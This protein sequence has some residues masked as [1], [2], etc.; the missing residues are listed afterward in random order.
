[1][2][3]LKYVNGQGFVG[4]LMV[5]LDFPNKSLLKSQKVMWDQEWSTLSILL[6]AAGW[7]DPV[8]ATYAY[9]MPVT[10]FDKKGKPKL[11]DGHVS[12][13]RDWLEREIAKVAP[14]KILC[15][16]E[17]GLWALSHT[18]RSVRS[19]RGMFM[20]YHDIPLMVTYPL[21]YLAGE[22]EYFLDVA[23]DVD[24]IV[25]CN[26][27]YAHP[28]IKTHVCL[29][30]EAVQAAFKLLLRE[31]IVTVDTET[32]GLRINQDK[33]ETIGFATCKPDKS[34][35][36]A[37]IIA[38]DVIDDPD[39]MELTRSFFR[40]CAK[41]QVKVIM[42]NAKFDM[43][44]ISN[45]LGIDFE[46]ID[47]QDTMMMNYAL[48]ERP[49]NSPASPHGLKSITRIRYDVPDYHFDFDS[50][51]A[52]EHKYRDWRDMYRY[53]AQD[54]VY[55]AWLYWDLVEEL[56]QEPAKKQL[57]ETLFIPGTK[58]LAAMEQAGAAIDV[59]YLIEQGK[60]L[61][62]EMIDAVA[63]CNKAIT[64]AGF[65]FADYASDVFNPGSYVHVAIVL[66]QMF[67]L[68]KL[69]GTRDRKKRGDDDEG[70]TSKEILDNLGYYLHN[71][72]KTHPH[73]T[74][75][76]QF[77]DAVLAYRAAGKTRST[78][79]VGLVS[80]AD[81]SGRLHASF[82]L[83]G[84]STGRLS[85]TEPPLQTIPQA[86]G[87]TVRR[88]FITPEGYF[89]LKIDY[90]QLEYRMAAQLSQDQRMIQAY[91]ER[92]DIHK[93]VASA[94]LGILP[95]M[96]NKAQRYAAKFIGFGILYGRGAESIA[97]G[98]ELRGYNWTVRDAEN[99][100]NKFLGQFVGL[101]S[102]MAGT[103]EAV[104]REQKLVTPTGRVRNWQ[105]IVPQ[106]VSTCQRQALNFP[107]QSLASD[108]TLSSLIKVREYLKG[109]KSY[110]MLI[111]HDEIDYAIHIDEA[112]EVIP[113]LIRIMSNPTIVDF[114]LPIDVEA[115]FGRSWGDLQHWDENWRAV[116]ESWQNQP[117]A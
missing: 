30:K 108:V 53:L 112:D 65:R 3:T 64:E 62:Q 56:E 25:N 21:F 76:E 34:D 5:I 29:T 8:Y 106:N 40:V 91:V 55:T 54:I 46:G 117:A 13:A 86:K 27:A 51:W 90:S 26:S 79:I 63:E 17:L 66:Y 9:P 35:S 59:E 113:E 77:I 52:V 73:G 87:L 92:R 10:T 41:R 95:E 32:S 18:R 15:M 37:Y 114:S 31:P 39:V 14:T 7:T 2:G 85:A 38:Y 33:I 89:W 57:L 93:E 88:G 98:P 97:K 23:R 68:P 28:P 45:W 43:T 80:K 107:I 83:S 116:Y 109:R 60:L 6:K 94:A 61:E 110:P 20:T 50:F 74:Y 22:P 82:N 42:H 1:M 49:I 100:I 75:A 96:V 102:W 48:D 103:R 11:D 71:E 115:E 81:A 72:G 19:I 4:G 84:T 47:L 111:V 24:K 104:V 36:A 44:F 69:K 101:K 99:F 67:K 105:Y 78:Y 12:A 16:G 70:G 58:A